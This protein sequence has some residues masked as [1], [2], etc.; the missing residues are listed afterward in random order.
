MRQVDHEARVASSATL[1]HLA[2]LEQGEPGAGR[3]LPEAARR[4]QAGEARPHDG[5]V[6][7][8]RAPQ[9]RPQR[10]WPQDLGPGGGAGVRWRAID[11]AKTHG[12]LSPVSELSRGSTRLGCT[13][14]WGRP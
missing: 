8:L 2:R 9:R 1:G 4:R 12:G 5:H 11:L 3:N 14:A 10:R 6:A 7:V 13:A